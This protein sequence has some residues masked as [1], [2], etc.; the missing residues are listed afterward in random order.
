MIRAKEYKPKIITEGV[1]YHNFKRYDNFVELKGS[2]NYSTSSGEY[3]I[4]E[5]QGLF[6]ISKPV[7]NSSFTIKF[8]KH[9]LKLSSLTLM[10]CIY[11]NCVNKLHVYG[12]NED[13]NRENICNIEEE[14]SEEVEGNE[15]GEVEGGSE[16]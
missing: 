6:W 7:S 1:F 2:S 15:E 10:S 11:N 14:E 16:E 12:S 4:I 8:Q 3:S 9:L 5:N 13:G